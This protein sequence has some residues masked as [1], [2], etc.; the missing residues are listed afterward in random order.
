VYRNPQG[1]AAHLKRGI[2]KTIH[3]VLRGL[4]RCSG[5]SKEFRENGT[6]RLP[7]FFWLENEESFKPVLAGKRDFDFNTNA[8][9][10]TADLIT[11][12]EKS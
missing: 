1:P 10:F 3:Q 9:V 11:K 5:D 6:G 8:N 2:W 12:F 7:I 4:L